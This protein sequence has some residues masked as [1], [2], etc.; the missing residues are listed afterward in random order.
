MNCDRDQGLCQQVGLSGYPSIRLYRGIYPGQD[1]QHPFGED[2]EIYE[3]QELLDYLHEILPEVS[4]QQP[5]ADR[6][7]FDHDEL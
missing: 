3:A 5:E 6:N 2:I 1:A 4:E 7:P